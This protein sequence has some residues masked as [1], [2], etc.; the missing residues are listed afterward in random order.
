MGRDKKNERRNS[1]FVK[2]TQHEFELPAWKALGPYSRLAYVSLKFRCITDGKYDNN[3][4]N[5]Y[6]SPRNLAA[7]LGCNE[8]TASKALAELQAKGFIICTKPWVKGT[9]GKGKS[10]KFRLTLLPTSD[11]NRSQGPTREPERWVEGRDYPILVYASHMPVGHQVAA[12]D[13]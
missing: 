5:V 13:G 6:R 9:S 11:K 7:D 4:G 2:L 3:N 8:K 12:S 1:R 10:A